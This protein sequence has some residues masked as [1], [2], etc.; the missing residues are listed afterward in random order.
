MPKLTYY[1]HFFVA[2]AL[3]SLFLGQEILWMRGAKSVTE[4]IKF[5]EC[6]NPNQVSSMMLKFLKF[7]KIRSLSSSVI[8]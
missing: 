8:K 5:G 3:R 1:M 2:A 7:L 6:C 4:K